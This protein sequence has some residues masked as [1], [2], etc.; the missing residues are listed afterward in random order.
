MRVRAV[1]DELD[2]ETDF[3]SE[4]SEFGKFVNDELFR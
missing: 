4:G 1:L 3:V 2:E